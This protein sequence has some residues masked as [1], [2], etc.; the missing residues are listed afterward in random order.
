M[1]ANLNGL[2]DEATLARLASELFAAL[3]GQTAGLDG[4]RG[5]AAPAAPQAA[6]GPPGLAAGLP[7]DGRPA[8]PAATE[9]S[10]LPDSLEECGI[11]AHVPPHHEA[12][13]GWDSLTPAAA[14]PAALSGVSADPYAPPRAQEFYFA[15]PLQ[16]GRPAAPATRRPRPGSFDAEAIRGDFPILAEHVNG[17][18][19]VW[20]DNAATT[21]KPQEVIDRLVR[22]YAHENSNIHRAAHELAARATQAYEDARGIAADFLGAP[23]SEDIVFVRGTTEA[24]N[25]VAQSW[26]RAHVGSGDEIVLSCLEHHAN[27]VPW[28]L[29]AEERG[30]ILRVI[31][32]D[33]SGQIILDEYRRLLTDRTRMVAIAHVS[34]ALGTILPLRE[35]IGAAHA[36]GAAVLVDGAQAVSHMPVDVQALD[37]DFYVFSGH[38]VLGPT[39]IGALYG[40]P[41]MLDSMPP[42]QGGGNMIRNVTFERTVYQPPPARFEAGTASIADAAGLGAALA[43]VDRIG[44]ANIASYEQ[45]LLTYATRALEAVP[46]LRLVGTAPDKAAILSFVLDGYR[47]EEVGSALNSEGIA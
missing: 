2:P 17:H 37:A 16:K 40:K 23:S 32:V 21:Q 11:T 13:P 30:A 3:P 9:L 47:P 28:Q 1:D 27:I 46:G 44:R 10:N 35:I 34:N 33:D 25:L 14:V 6:A 7:A 26:G 8:S 39:G 12:V 43:Y 45:E 15:A 5:P 42:W 31:P 24:I 19:L 4:H 41:H 29:L 18:Q 20:L 38:K 22:F 36:A